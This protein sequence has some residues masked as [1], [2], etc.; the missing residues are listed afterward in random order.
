[1]IAAAAAPVTPRPDMLRNARRSRP[2][3]VPLSSKFCICGP[4]IDHAGI[5][6]EPAD[7]GW[8]DIP[9]LAL[10]RTARPAGYD[11]MASNHANLLWRASLVFCR[12]WNGR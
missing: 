9:T 10:I 8:F 11:N 1:M 2:R 4:F 7:Y 5:S 12:L 6:D 3:F